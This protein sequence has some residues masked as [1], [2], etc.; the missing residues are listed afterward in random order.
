MKSFFQFIIDVLTMGIG[1]ANAAQAAAAEGEARAAIRAAQ[2]AQQ[3]EERL[4]PVGANDRYSRQQARA[5]KRAVMKELRSM[6]KASA[7]KHKDPG[8]AAAVR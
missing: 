7:M 6:R 1:P 8:G 5:E 2:L 3:N 4:G